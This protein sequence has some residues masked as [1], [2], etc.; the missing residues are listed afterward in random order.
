MYLLHNCPVFAIL[1]VL[2]GNWFTSSLCLYVILELILEWHW[3][4]RRRS[5]SDSYS[6]NCYEAFIKK[7]EL[8][9]FVQMLFTLVFEYVSLRF[10]KCVGKCFHG[11]LHNCVKFIEYVRRAVLHTCRQIVCLY[12]FSI[13]VRQCFAQQSIAKHSSLHFSFD[14]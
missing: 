2:L 5:H 10:T 1:L 11:I 6:R 8:R 13:R 4:I 12:S 14:N 7:F 9:N 3:H